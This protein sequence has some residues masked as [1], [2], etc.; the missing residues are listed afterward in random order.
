MI[1]CPSCNEEIENGSYYCDQCGQELMYCSRCG[2]VGTGRHCTYCGGLMAVGSEVPFTEAIPGLIMTNRLQNIRMV[3]ISGAII[4]RREGPYTGVL[5]VN[6]YISGVHAQ[7]V[8]ERDAGWCIIDMNS[9]NGTKLNEKQLV[10]NVK[11]PLSK[12][13][14]LSIATLNLHIDIE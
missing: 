11:V 14:I 8:Y 9:S 12:G 2:R 4:G 7:L 10:S 5:S 3:G 6:K 1:T 13:D